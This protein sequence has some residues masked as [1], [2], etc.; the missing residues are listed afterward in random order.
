MFC[1]AARL[2]LRFSLALELR[3]EELDNWSESCKSKSGRMRRESE[4]LT[5]NW[6]LS[7]TLLWL[8]QVSETST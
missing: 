8:W 6:C 1:R 2:V 7:E 5:H 3:E 4:T